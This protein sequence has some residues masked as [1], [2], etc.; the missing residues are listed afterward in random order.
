[1]APS[2]TPNVRRGDDGN[3]SHDSND[4]VS[5][6]ESPEQTT[7]SS[8]G[9]N[10]AQALRDLARG[11]QTANTL[12]ANLTSLESKLDQIL[13]SFGISPEE[14]DGLD[15]KEGKGDEKDGKKHGEKE[16]DGENK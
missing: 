3:A 10:L 13:A 7:S 16:V 4:Q 5:A 2:A 8:V 12:E 6:R 11:E 9:D 15:E 1:M 14:L